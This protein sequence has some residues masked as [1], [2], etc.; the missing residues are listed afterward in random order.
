MKE[1]KWAFGKR[2]KILLIV[3]L[4]LFVFLCVKSL[5]LDPFTP[6]DDEERQLAD[7]A[8]E[9][10]QTQGILRWRVIDVKDLRN[11]REGLE[12]Q[13]VVELRRYLFYIFP[14]GHGSVYR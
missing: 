13:K 4:V 2:E 1:N 10:L 3:V 5:L 8:L 9:G 7:E 6:G 12:Y 11:E 14:F